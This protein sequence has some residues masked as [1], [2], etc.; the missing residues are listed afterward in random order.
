MRGT[1]PGPPT[2]PRFEPPLVHHR[3]CICCACCFCT[4]PRE[5][6]PPWPDDG[7]LLPPTPAVPNPA[8]ALLGQPH[9]LSWLPDDFR[10]SCISYRMSCPRVWQQH[11][12]TSA[13][14]TGVLLWGVVRW[15]QNTQHMAGPPNGFD[16]SMHQSKVC[17][18]DRSVMAPY[19]Q[20]AP[21]A[22]PLQSIIVVWARHIPYSAPAHVTYFEPEEAVG[23]NGNQEAV[24]DGPANGSLRWTSRLCVCVASIGWLEIN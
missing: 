10:R 22:Y 11:A 19:Q 24:A 17:G 16:S 9:H 6:E 8:S 7:P 21:S 18:S 4:C 14:S 1:W 5:P 13:A 23:R 15:V 20:I 3:G 12:P 2:I